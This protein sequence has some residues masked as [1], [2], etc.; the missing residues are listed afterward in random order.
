MPTQMHATVTQASPLRVRVDGADTDSPAVVYGN[1]SFL[2]GARVDVT[3]RNPEPPLVIVGGDVDAKTLDGKDSSG[4][5]QKGLVGSGT[6]GARNTHRVTTLNDYWASGW[7]D[8]DNMTGA[9]STAWWLVQV[10]S[11]SNG[12]HWQRQIAYA[13]T[14][15]QITQSVYSRRCNGGDPTVAGSWTAWQL[16]AG[17]GAWQYPTLGN[18]WVDYSPAYR[19]RFRA[20]PGGVVRIAGLA[21]SGNLDAPAFV[22]PLGMR[23]SDNSQHFA[24][25][26]VSGTSRIHGEFFVGNNG[27]VTPYTGGN[28]EFSLA[29]TFGLGI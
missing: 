10:I 19:V 7:Y 14:G 24:T 11:H 29:C 9:P 22:L 6:P 21:K 8:G 25:H 27:N 18:G 28:A 3:I 12:A 15:E 17:S 16:V 13:M 4:F 1:L 5:L 20:E 26:S 23:P 2:V